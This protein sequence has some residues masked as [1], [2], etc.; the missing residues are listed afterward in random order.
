NMKDRRDRSSRNASSSRETVCCGAGETEGCRQLA[1]AAADSVR[2]A[3]NDRIRTFRDPRG[4]APRTP[5][6]ALSRAAS[7]ARSVPVAHSLR[8]FA[9]SSPASEFPF[10]RRFGTLLERV[11]Q[12]E[13]QAAAAVVHRAGRLT[14]VRVDARQHRNVAVEAGEVRRVEDVEPFERDGRA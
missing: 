2:T 7:P 1:T 8:S 5:L 12:A 6:H 9:S 4:F 3:T 10:T 11:T 14:E 13:L